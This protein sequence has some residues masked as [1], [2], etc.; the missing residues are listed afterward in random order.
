MDTTLD[1]IDLISDDDGTVTAVVADNGSVD[2][3]APGAPGDP[4]V[5]GG[6]EGGDGGDEGTC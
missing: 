6:D 2:P 4:G 1:L 3:G 5:D